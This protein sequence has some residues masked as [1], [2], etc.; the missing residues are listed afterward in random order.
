MVAL[1]DFPLMYGIVWVGNTVEEILLTTWDVLNLVNNGINYQP[2]LVN[3][4]ISE[5]S[6]V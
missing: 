5:P 1:K 4:R 2:Q 6:T 3:R